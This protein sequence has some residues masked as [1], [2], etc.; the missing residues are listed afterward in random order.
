MDYFL[1]RCKLS[2]SYCY[3]ILVETFKTEKWRFVISFIIEWFV[4]ERALK[5]I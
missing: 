3:C 2:Q 4:L 1:R 5:T